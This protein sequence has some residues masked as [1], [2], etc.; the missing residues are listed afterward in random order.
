MYSLHN[1]RFISVLAG[2]VC[3]HFLI[4]IFVSLKV[5]KLRTFNIAA[6]GDGVVFSMALESVFINLQCAVRIFHFIVCLFFFRHISSCINIC[7]AVSLFYSFLSIVLLFNMYSFHN[8]RFIS[9]SAGSVCSH[10][11][12]SVC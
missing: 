6:S 11:L 12:I 8:P 2:S 5:V 4:S 1:P 10:V 3:L 9:L 7:S